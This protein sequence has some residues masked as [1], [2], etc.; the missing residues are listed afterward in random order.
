MKRIPSTS[1]L[2]VS[3]ITVV[4]NDCNTIGQSIESVVNQDYSDIEYIVIDGKSNDGTKDVIEKYRDHIDTF[5]SEE[6]NGMYHAMNKG[7]AVASGDIIGILN[8]D[9]FYSSTD[10]ISKVV[11]KFD[12]TNCDGLY[13]DLVY[14]DRKNAKKIIRYFKAGVQQSFLS[15][16]HPPHPTFFVRKEIYWKYGSYNTSLKIAADFEMMLRLIEKEKIRLAYIDETIVKMRTG[17]ASN[18]SFWNILK[19]YFQNRKSF[20]INEIKYPI[21]YPFIRYLSKIKQ[22]IYH[23]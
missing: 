21:F 23:S 15:G 12:Q 3:I 6:D 13:A 11:N 20:I 10:I 9:D 5:V 19:T 14:V 8:A 4:F 18:K 16:W 7:I 22:Y 17:G 2:K 1:V